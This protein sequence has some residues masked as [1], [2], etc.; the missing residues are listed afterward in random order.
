MSIR[1]VFIDTSLPEYEILVTKYDT[2]AFNIILLADP[3][4]GYLQIQDYLTANSLSAA[5]INVVSAS[6]SLNGV[7]TPRVVFIDPTVAK[8]QALIADMPVNAT[9][10]VLDASLDGVQQIIDYLTNNAGV[11]GAI[12]IITNIDSLDVVSHG[13]SGEIT[14]G[15]TVLNSDTMAN[16]ASQLA[17]IGSY[18]TSNGDILLYG[19]DVADDAIGQQ[20]IEQLAVATGADVAASTNLTGGAAIGGD[21]VLEANTGTIETVAI[22]NLGYE[23]VLTASVPDLDTAD[24]TGTSSADNITNQTANLTFKG[25]KANNSTVILFNDI[26]N[27]GIR[28]SGENLATESGSGTNYSFDVSLSAGTHYIR[29]QQTTGSLQNVSNAL[30]VI[31]DTTPPAAANVTPSGNEDST[32]TV[33]LSATDGGSGVAFYKLSSLPS[34]GTLYTDAGA[35]IAANTGAN[36]TSNTFYF[37]PTANYNGSASFS[38]VANDVAGNTSSSATATITVNP[39]NDAPTGTAS[40]VLAAGTEDTA[41]TILA[42][43][44]LQGFSDVDGDGDTLSVTN[45][46]ATNGTLAAAAGGWT[47]TPA[48]NYNGAVDLTYDVT[49]GTASVG[50]TQS[51]SLAAVNDVATISVSGTPDTSVTEKGYTVAGDANASGNLTVTDVD[52]GENKFSTPSSLSGTYGAF[53]FSI[54][55]GAWSYLLNDTLPVTQALKA[56]EQKIESLNVVSLDGTATRNIQ[57]TVN[58]TNDAPTVLGVSKTVQET[59]TVDLTDLLLGAASDVDSS[60][61]SLLLSSGGSLSGVSSKG[62]PIDIVDGRLYY[63]ATADSFDTTTKSL[64]DTF[65]FFVKDA[66]GAVSSAATVTLT[67]QQGTASTAT[68]YLTN[69]NDTYGPFDTNDIVYGNNGNDTLNGGLGKD[70][71]D[72][73]NGNDVLF[74]DDGNDILIGNNGDDNLTGGVGADTL[75]GGRGNDILRGDNLSLALKGAD[76]FV[77]DKAS[78]ADIILDFNKGGGTYNPLEGDKIWV[79]SDTGTTSFSQIK[80]IESTYSGDYAAVVS[81]GS[82]GQVTLV[83]VHAS[84][85]NDSLFTFSSALPTGL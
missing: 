85:V 70:K 32:I 72:G 11:V 13:T 23:G 14:L 63:Q 38:Y 17:E 55:T 5:D 66:E 7:F 2:S 50:A 76:I 12:D 33:T 30:K 8:Y 43:D 37:K 31:I 45:L 77:S 24:D 18:L 52:Q 73:G 19:C 42:S 46:M 28:E 44:L 68:V 40:A 83:G 82:G 57:V 47:F 64:T 20:F 59:Q 56:G 80:V 27:N 1:T 67:V 48:A 29:A 10:V 49:D 35:T 26:N 62:S 15:S 60:V 34:N 65:S 78:G 53:T 81:M 51:F 6:A 22:S 25:T 9:I 58:G 3:L 71:L 39:V 4:I 79:R 16:Y 69:G 54:D 41:Y 84:D 74:G 75:Y 61:F 36:Y 21:W